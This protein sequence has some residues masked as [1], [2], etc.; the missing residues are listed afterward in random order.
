MATITGTSGN[1]TLS[2]DTT[3]PGTINDSINGL[4]GDDVL[5]GLTGNDTLIGE[6]GNDSLFGGT[7]DDSLYGG[8]NSDLLEGGS[9]A[10]LLRG[11]NR[12]GNG[13]DDGRDTVSYA[14]STAG[15]AVT[16]N[17]SGIGGDAQGDTLVN[18]EDLIGSN[19]N[20]TLTGSSAANFLYGG[21]G[22]DSLNGEGGAD[23]L[24]GGIGSDSLSGGAGIDTLY[25]DADN[26]LLNG[27]NDGDL[28][29]GGTGNDSLF[30]DVGNGA[31]A[32]TL[33]GGENDDL[34]EGGGGGDSLFGDEGN[35]SLAGQAGVDT[36]SGGEGNDALSGGTDNDVLFGGGGND[37]L[38]GE[39]GR[40][41]LEGGSGND[42]LYG[43]AED[44]TL[45]GG[46]NDDLIAGGLGNDLLAG[47]DGIDT[48]T[49]ANSATGVTANLGSGIA[50][51][52]GTDTISGFENLV[53]SAN[54][55]VL[56]G[57]GDANVIDGGAGADRVF[58]GAGDDSLLGGAGNDSIGAG[59]GNDT[60][61]AG[62]GSDSVDGGS[63][64]DLIYGGSNGTVLASFITNGTFTGGGAGWT[65][66]DIEFNPE[67]AY[68]PG[69]L[70]NG[71]TEVDG[72]AGQITQ[73]NQSF[74]VDGA[75]SALLTFRGVVRTSGDV[76]QDGYRVQ[77]LGSAGNVVAEREFLPGSSWAN[78][79]LDISFPAAD[80]YT[81]RFTE[82]G[83]NDSTGALVDDVQ[84][85]ATSFAQD[86]GDTLS[87]GE[88]RDTIYGGAGDDSIRGDANDD[89][90]YGGAG[91]D[92]VEGGGGNDV[93]LGDVGN[94]TLSGGLD[95]DSLFGEDGNDSLRGDEGDDTLVGGA[96]T[97]WMSGGSGNDLFLYSV[98]DILG[99]ATETVRGDGT[100]STQNDLLTDN[101][102]IDLTSF[103]AQY[104]W[105]SI[106]I[107]RGSLN[108]LDPAF[109]NGTISLY[110]GNPA[111]GGQLIGTIDF[112][113]IEDIIRCFTPGTMILT[114]RGE[115]AVEA[116]M[117]GDL[118]MTRDSGLQPL[119]WVGRQHVTRA[120]LLADPD[121]QPVRIAAGALGID[122]PERSML[123]SPQ[124][125]VL[126]TGAR[127]ELL[128]GEDEV[129]VPAKHLVG[130]AEVTR[131]LPEDGVTYIHIL[132]DRH[133]IVQSDGI[134]TESFQPAERM[135]NAMEAEVRDEIL[136][137]FPELATDTSAYE[138]A[139][140]SLKAHEARVLLAS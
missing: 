8:D 43:G 90:L 5:F 14:G 2:G 20:D 137:I 89:Q 62:L 10:D 108:P 70:A 52:E 134:W 41:A 23:S 101:D 57:N 80:T 115:V 73:L 48:L 63:G 74:T 100:G 136:K 34:I 120:R 16:V 64:D 33:Y 127:A 121:L 66:T 135:L 71:V 50:T 44:D 37:S 84:I 27:G 42:S 3:L 75:Q 13:G 56:T 91:S 18:I 47:N 126:V 49:Y 124:H 69:G 117:A 138:G 99:G 31:F 25:G 24:F 119:R 28:L 12:T 106:V 139:R 72:N 58:G 77:V 38:F 59:G 112:N 122:E 15:V 29:Y 30:G 26:D 22:G 36:L 104:G 131:A 51:G 85:T 129:L 133:E 98:N 60:V 103:G 6:A 81:L 132:F 9:G 7:G 110:D 82:L 55:D 113:N 88:G 19:Q 94:D 111:L 76:G 21:A 95:D 53:G 83:D 35:D 67:S 140:L 93:L 46:E 118:V 79:S 65:G 40:D 61:D 45:R 54:N 17:G 92:V 125:R 114:D 86:A 78:Y 11:N 97:D 128:F 87:G 4:A 96:G 130:H 1:D 39:E 107:D 105:R 109:E 123:V 116:L 102:T 32:D 68:L